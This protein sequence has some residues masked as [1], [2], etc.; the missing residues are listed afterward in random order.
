V[1]ASYGLPGSAPSR[2]TGHKESGM[3]SK[4]RARCLKK[5]CK[6]RAEYGVN[7]PIHC[8]IHKDDNDI[9]MVERTCEKCGKIDVLR[10]DN[11][12]INFC[13]MEESDVKYKRRQK[14]KESRVVSLLTEHFGEPN[15]CDRIVENECEIKQRPD[16]VY[17]CKTHIVI[18]EIDENRHRSYCD[19]GEVNKMKNIY[20]AYGGEM[21]IVFIR[22]NPDKFKVD[23]KVVNIPNEKKEKMLLL[24]VKKA[25]NEIPTGMIS[26]IYLYYDNYRE[27]QRDFYNIDP[28]EKVAECVQCGKS[29]FRTVPHE[30]E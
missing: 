12:C 3:I 20:T 29:Y 9:N 7:R 14:L 2:C 4:P 6:N 8:Q 22:Y 21:P 10:E 17:E 13:S 19:L 30:C 26:I 27:T 15:I 5:N 18:C 1:R 25:I 23:G 24:W 28:Y 11:I 16:I